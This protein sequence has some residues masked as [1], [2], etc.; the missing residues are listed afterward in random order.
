[1]DREFPGCPFER[2]AD[3][4]VI[5]CNTEA[6]ARRL[7]AA[8]AERLGSVGLELHPVKTR[9]LEFGPFA[10]ASR[11]RLAQHAGAR[12]RLLAPAAQILLAEP[13]LPIAAD[14]ASALRSWSRGAVSSRLFG[15]LCSPFFFSQSRQRVLPSETGNPQELHFCTRCIASGT[16]AGADA[17]AVAS[18]G[19]DDAAGGPSANSG[20][21]QIA[22]IVCSFGALLTLARS[23]KTSE[24]FPDSRLATGCRRCSDRS[25]AV[26]VRSA[27]RS[28]AIRSRSSKAYG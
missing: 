12:L 24:G 3:D 7:L 17:A 28:R 10:V 16:A 6:Q 2:Y 22:G 21:R 8:L 14:S 23:G 20:G 19:M 25:R 18:E 26:K 9:L 4:A 15:R 27:M 5:H 13:E 11:K 1:M